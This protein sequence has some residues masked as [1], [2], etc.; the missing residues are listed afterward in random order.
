MVVPITDKGLLRRRLR[1]SASVPSRRVFPGDAV[2]EELSERLAGV[3]RQFSTAVAYGA[4]RTAWG[5][6]I[7]QSGQKPR[8]FSGSSR[9]SGTLTASAFPGVVADEETCRSETRP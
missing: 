4:V 1:R 7:E 9:R 6:A 8:A 2:V 5:A 3:E